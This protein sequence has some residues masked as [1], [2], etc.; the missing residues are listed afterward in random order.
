MKRILTV[1]VIC[2]L[3][4]LMLTACGKK[5]A[6]TNDEF[7]KK[8]QDNG[9]ITEDQAEQYSGYDHVKSVT[10]AG[11][12]DGND[13]KWT[14]DFM[15]A[16]DESKAKEMFENNKTTFENSTDGTTS[17]S[18]V[19]MG[20]YNTFELN[21]NGKYMYLCRVDNTLVYFNVDE[22]YKDDAKKFIKA[23]GY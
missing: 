4:M 7:I 21:A 13:V 3:V 15:I 9:M 10:T 23:L 22:A 8:A 5:T 20:N 12:V 6:L 19:N 16:V 2:V 17:S 11:I 18:S 1:S 14:C